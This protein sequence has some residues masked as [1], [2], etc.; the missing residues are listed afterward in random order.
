MHWHFPVILNTLILSPWIVEQ[1]TE[2]SL[3][4][5]AYPIGESV[6]T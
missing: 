3:E 1:K 4:I 5:W 6:L 2:V